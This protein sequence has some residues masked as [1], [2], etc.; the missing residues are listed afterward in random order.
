MYSKKR[1]LKLL[2]ENLMQGPYSENHLFINLPDGSFVEGSGLCDIIS[3][4][5]YKKL[6][7]RSTWFY[8]K[9]E[10]EEYA[11]HNKKSKSWFLWKSVKGR[12]K[13]CKNLYDKLCENDK[14]SKSNKNTK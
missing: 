10:I 7:A 12:K 2:S 13:F 5:S 6:I 3:K 11:K 9:C 1:I 14:Q 8:I 4:L